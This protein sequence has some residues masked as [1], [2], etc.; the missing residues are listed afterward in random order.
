MGSLDVSSTSGDQVLSS[1][2]NRD[3]VVRAGGSVGQPKNNNTGFEG[4]R[5]LLLFVLLNISV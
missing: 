4:Q 5:P 3:L 2:G 1:F